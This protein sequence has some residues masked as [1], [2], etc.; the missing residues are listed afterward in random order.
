MNINSWNEEDKTNLLDFLR[1]CKEN[2]KLPLSIAASNFFDGNYVTTEGSSSPFN[3]GDFISAPGFKKQRH[4]IPLFNQ[5]YDQKKKKENKIYNFNDK[6]K[7]YLIKLF[8][9]FI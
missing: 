5:Y 2:G 4:I 1:S 6:I 7:N 8:Q 9:I 3:M